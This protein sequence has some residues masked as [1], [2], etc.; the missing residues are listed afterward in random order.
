MAVSNWR[1]RRK[2]TRGAVKFD[3]KLVKW[4]KGRKKAIEMSPPTD[5]LIEI[6]VGSL[7]IFRDK[8][9]DIEEEKRKFLEK[10]KGKLI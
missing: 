7:S 2:D 5:H 9:C 8:D 3:E 1:I 10:Y 6:K 4:E